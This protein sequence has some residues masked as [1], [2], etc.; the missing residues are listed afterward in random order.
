MTDDPVLNSF[1]DRKFK[2]NKTFKIDKLIEKIKTG[3][4]IPKG[5]LVI[6]ASGDTQLRLKILEKETPNKGFSMPLILNEF[7]KSKRNAD[8]SVPFT[9]RRLF[10]RSLRLKALFT[11]HAR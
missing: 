8:F 5:T 11:F 1:L 4:N 2:G 10:V 3:E 6:M 9:L 7:A